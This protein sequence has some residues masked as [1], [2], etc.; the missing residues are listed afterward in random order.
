MCQLSEAFSLPNRCLIVLSEMLLALEKKQIP[1]KCIVYGELL[2]GL[3]KVRD[4]KIT[5][6]II[7]GSY[8]Q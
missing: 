3:V 1:E 7:V 2:L 8:N 5:D 6:K 4:P